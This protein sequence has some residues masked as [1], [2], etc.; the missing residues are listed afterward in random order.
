MFSRNEEKNCGGIG[1]DGGEVIKKENVVNLLE[2]INLYEE[3]A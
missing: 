1:E 2:R 3:F